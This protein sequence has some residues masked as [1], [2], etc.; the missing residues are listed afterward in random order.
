MDVAAPARRRLLLAGAVALTTCAGSA[1]PAFAGALLPERGGSPNADRI[2]S[3]YTVVLVIAAIVFAGVV[4]ALVSA[5]VRF[6]E[7]RNPVAAQTR[8]NTRLELGWTAA[9]TGLIVF[10]AVLSFTKLDAIEHPDRAAADRGAAVVAGVADDE[11]GA[12]QID[13]VGRQYVW[14][15]EYPNG[16]HSYGEL[17]APVGVTVEL[18]IRSVDVAH[19]WWIPKLGGKFDASPATSTTRGSVPP[20]PGSTGG[21]AP[22]CA[23]ATTRTWWPRC[24]RCPPRPTPAGWL[25]RSA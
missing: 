21:S 15:F 1:P 10:L 11:R 20:V 25:A 16:A 23:G 9:A 13:I 14:K 19:S 18:H 4:V 8:G 24:V 5:L 22:S 6:R 17:V 3:L 7:D 12:L 2:A